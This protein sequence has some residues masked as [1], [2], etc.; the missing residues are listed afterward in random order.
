MENQNTLY[1]NDLAKES[2]RVS[3]RWCLFLAVLGFIGLALM[4][5]V[6]LFWGFSTQSNPG[7][8]IFGAA[9][10][11]IGVFY[12]LCAAFYIPPVVYLY[13]YATATTEALR[14]NSAESLAFALQNLKSHHKYLG[15]SMIVLISLY[16]L[17]VIGL[18]IYMMRMTRG[19]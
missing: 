10:K 13:R 14:I 18:V 8:G 6:G 2:L 7:F 11:G 1:L 17:M 16:I 12:I 4:L 15:I 19:F 5:L 9:K 3:A